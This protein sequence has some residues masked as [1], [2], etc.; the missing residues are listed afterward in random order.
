MRN[1]PTNAG[2]TYERGGGGVEF[3]EIGGGRVDDALQVRQRHRQRRR[4]VPETEAK[5]RET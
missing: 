4:G 5:H 1:S 2:L 3:G